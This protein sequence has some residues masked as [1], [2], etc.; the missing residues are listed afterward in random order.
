MRF[1][2]WNSRASSPPPQIDSLPQ[3]TVAIDLSPCRP[4]ER[5]GLRKGEQSISPWRDDDV[6]TEAFQSK[7][8]GWWLPPD[9]AVVRARGAVGMRSRA[10]GVAR[11]E[12]V[13]APLSSM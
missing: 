1:D 3:R 13:A 9:A 5:L 10:S 2:L 12:A 4:A 6:R 7:N 11:M 8:S